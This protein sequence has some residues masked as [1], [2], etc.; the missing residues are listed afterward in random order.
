MAESYYYDRFTSFV[1][2]VRYSVGPIIFRLV[3]SLLERSHCSQASFIQIL[4]FSLNLGLMTYVETKNN[5]NYVMNRI[6]HFMRV[7]LL[8]PIHTN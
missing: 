1:L 4:V 7:S 3:K 2:T 5:T 6:F 8:R